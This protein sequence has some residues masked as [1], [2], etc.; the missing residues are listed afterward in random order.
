MSVLLS[1]H[2]VE[3]MHTAFHALTLPLDEVERT[4]TRTP[5]P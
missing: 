5:W 4:D 3:Y 1:L 2:L